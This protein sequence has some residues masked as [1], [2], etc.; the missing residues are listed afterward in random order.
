MKRNAQNR[1][2]AAIGLLLILVMSSTF[3]SLQVVAQRNFPTVAP[4][5]GAR[6][7]EAAATVQAGQAQIRATAAAGQTQA[8]ATVQ[9]GQTQ[10]ASTAQALPT[11]IQATA[12]AARTSV[13]VTV[14]TY[15]TEVVA[16]VDALRTTTYATVD[17]LRTEVVATLQVF[18]DELN[19]AL[20]VI[21]VS[22][23]ET[24]GIVTLTTT[25]EESQLNA[26]IEV[27]MLAAG[28][29]QIDATVDLV[30]N[31]LIMT[32]ENF[33]LE[34]GQVV[35]ASLEYVL[36]ERDGV[37][38]LVL[39][40]VTVNGVSLPLDQIDELLPLY[41][42]S[43]LE[44]IINGSTSDFEAYLPEGMT[45]VEVQVDRVLITEDLVAV[46]MVGSVT[47]Q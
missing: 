35:T 27:V 8:V 36:V 47:Q 37:Y 44:D 10:L 1:I 12:D 38:S 33:T 26:A 20:S 18:A 16:T 21:D 45:L 9:A 43:Y 30:N 17:A 2:L 42:A 13:N 41:L 32:L 5:D 40:D 28:Y 6:L 11:N 29:D 7:T 39:I 31:G 34:T 25:I 46:V 4:R 14:D 19:D 15:T 23:D 3:V 22:Y 24:D